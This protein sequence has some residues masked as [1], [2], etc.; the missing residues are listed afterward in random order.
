MVTSSAM[1]ALAVTLAAPPE[2]RFYEV[3]ATPRRALHGG[4]IRRHHPIV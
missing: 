1:R 4:P 2:S 3:H